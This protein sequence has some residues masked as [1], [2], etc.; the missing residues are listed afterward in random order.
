MRVKQKRRF[1]YHIVRIAF[2]IS[3]AILLTRFP[4]HYLESYF[5]DLR[6]RLSPTHAP[7][8]AIQTVAID[9]ESI[10]ELLRTPNIED[11][12]IALKN[13]LESKPL[14]IVY[15]LDPSEF[16]GTPQQK[17]E[18][19]NLASDKSVYVTSS[20]PK[21]EG[22]EQ[23]LVLSPPFDKIQ[24]VFAPK[25]ADQKSFAKDGVTRRAVVTYHNRP[26]LH[27]ELARKYNPQVYLEDLHG[28]F[29]VLNSLQLYIRFHPPQT[30]VPTSLI[31]VIQ[32]KP[33]T[34]EFN[35]KIIFVGRDDKTQAT[36][37]IQTPYSREVTGLS[38]LEMHANI[39][40]TFLQNSAP[41][42]SPQW[43]D[44]LTTAIVS[45]ITVYVVLTLKPSL[46]LAI[47]ALTGFLFSVYAYALFAFMG[48]WVGAIHPLLSIFICYYFF[49][50]Y[51]L[52]MENRRSWE[53]YQKN[54]LLTQV[55]ELK[56]NFMS[57][58]SHDLKTP[59]AR[60]QGM[61][62]ILK[63]EQKQLSH[64]QL[65]AIESIQGSTTELIHFF[66]SILD[67]SR[68]ESNVIKL[69]LSSK[70]INSLL[71]EV[72]Q[73]LDFVAK[74]KNI[75]ILT[76]FEPLFSVKIDADLIRQVLSNLI[77]N[78]IKYS[79]NNTRILITT[80]DSVDKVVIQIADQGIGMS[81]EEL[82]RVFMKFYRSKDVKTSTTKGS[83][84]GLYLSKYFVELH[85][86]TISVESAP[87]KGSTFTVE[88]PTNL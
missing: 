68:I 51:R 65:D 15:T 72:I 80:E 69:H 43:V 29:D 73:K 82:E 67:L 27:L 9:N 22:Q 59:L 3:T 81:E 6:L 36:D 13:L 42:K 84:L 38:H 87:G 25:T 74:K 61:L 5:Y 63:Q 85:N 21:A 33:K 88:L 39:M 4:L 44:V 77:E 10:K 28:V 32:N 30:F 60:I 56:S 83:G 70:D 37:Y 52:I 41:I 66:N 76:E 12:T 14:A 7:S 23:E 86:G 46:G 55:E 2:A 40:D 48:V 64:K 18:F 47:L 11:H 24:V 1:V 71:Q 34:Q 45:G 16:E 75:E 57:M 35:N 26:T 62:D 19:A 53:Y 78:A 17:L 8:E 50:P 79:P 54:K 20:V 49:I 58:M 31:D